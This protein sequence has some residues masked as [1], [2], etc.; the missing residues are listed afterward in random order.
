MHK[1]KGLKPH[2]IPCTCYSVFH[3]PCASS[4]LVTED[5]CMSPRCLKGKQ[6]SSSQLNFK[7][8]TW[9]L[10][11]LDY[12]LTLL[13]LWK[14]C[15]CFKHS[16]HEGEWGPQNPAHVEE[17]E[18]NWSN[19]VVLG[20]YMRHLSFEQISVAVV[21]KSPRNFFNLSDSYQLDSIEL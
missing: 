9:A 1:G 3:F 16:R 6:C 20:W 17:A 8:I 5:S 21:E 18:Q 2:G 19:T 7:S 14:S 12:I 10:N 11:L 15:R 4:C 13:Y